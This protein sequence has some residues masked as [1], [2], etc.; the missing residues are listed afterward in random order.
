MSKT[1]L[2]ILCG[3]LLLICSIWRDYLWLGGSGPMRTYA[4]F[5][6]RFDN[7]LIG[8]LLAL[9]PIH[10]GWPE[11]M[12]QYVWLPLTA[13]MAFAIWL[14]WDSNQ[15]QLGMIMTAV[16]SAWILVAVLTDPKGRLARTLRLRPINYLGRI[17]YGYYLWHF[18]IWLCLGWFL[19][20]S[21]YTRAALTVAIAV[22]VAAVSYHWL[23]LPVRRS[24]GNPT[25]TPQ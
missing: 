14:K 8:C 11:T 13:L 9:V 21:L 22:S 25:R 1:H 16:C 4:G 5:D 18:P 23:E 15:Y 17:S 3:T 6:T 19:P 7:L 24:K 20:G 10:R 12:A 2:M